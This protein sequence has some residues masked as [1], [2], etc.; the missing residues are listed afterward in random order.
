VSSINNDTATTQSSPSPVFAELKQM[1]GAK[2]T[3]NTGKPIVKSSPTFAKTSNQF[4]SVVHKISDKTSPSNTSAVA[5]NKNSA[6]SAATTT[7]MTTSSSS[8][9]LAAEPTEQHNNKVRY[10]PPTTEANEILKVQPDPPEEQRKIAEEKKED[11]EEMNLDHYLR[12]SRMNSMENQYQQCQHQQTDP[13]ATIPRF[14]ELRQMWTANA[15]QH[16][17]VEKENEEVRLPPVVIPEVSPSK[18]DRRGSAVDND[19]SDHFDFEVSKNTVTG[20]K[21]TVLLPDSTD[22]AQYLTKLSAVPRSEDSDEDD[23]FQ[24]LRLNPLQCELKVMKTSAV[25]MNNHAKRSQD[26]YQAMLDLT[27]EYRT[28][29]STKP[30]AMNSTSKETSPVNAYIQKFEALSKGENVS[31]NSGDVTSGPGTTSPPNRFSFYDA[32]K[33]TLSMLNKMSEPTE[34]GDT[35]EDRTPVATFSTQSNEKTNKNT[36]DS[37]PSMIPEV[38]SAEKKLQ[39]NS[40]SGSVSPGTKKKQ[41]VSKVKL[42]AAKLSSASAKKSPKRANKPTVTKKEEPRRET[43]QD[44]PDSSILTDTMTM[45]G[46]MDLSLAL[47]EET[48]D[49]AMVLVNLSSKYSSHNEP[50]SPNQVQRVRSPALSDTV[51]VHPQSK[52]GGVCSIM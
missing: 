3:I 51:Q 28:E 46:G 42:A 37:Q 1:W 21:Q 24:T 19:Y 36:A 30:P 4:G 25:S 38:N 39:K 23:D 26:K 9:S 27:A 47:D 18:M 14:D 35:V 31:M 5:V 43:P 50:A 34:K 11:P 15:R 40:P 20:P 49:N 10:D 52:C 33:E 17:V 8:S 22:R 48:Y 7:S 2:S 41:A 6:H 32:G 45:A 16:A 44:N 13:D 29:E 12:N